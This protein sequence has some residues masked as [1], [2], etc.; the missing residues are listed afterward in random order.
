MA[1]ARLVAKAGIL[2]EKGQFLILT[3]SDTDM[4]RP[5]ELDLPGGRVE[6]GEN[7]EDAIV[8]EISEETGLVL[9]RE[10]LNLV[11]TSTVFYEE[12]STIRFLFAASIASPPEIMLSFEHSA[13]AWMGLD[14]VELKFSHPVWVEGLRYASEHDLLPKL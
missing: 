13:Y 10:Q 5:G 8:R 12:S 4:I 1:K 6:L 14:E 7:I 9:L 11:Y 2:N 3:R